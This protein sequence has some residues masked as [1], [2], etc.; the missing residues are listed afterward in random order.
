[1]ERNYSLDN[2]T[3]LDILRQKLEHNNT[4]QEMT[5]RPGFLKINSLVFLKTQ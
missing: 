2:G 3:A 5:L 1:M 4:T